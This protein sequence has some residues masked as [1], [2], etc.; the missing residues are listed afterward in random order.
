MSSSVHHISEELVEQSARIN[1]DPPWRIRTGLLEGR[2]L[3]AGEG[4]FT[5]A[6][7][8]IRGSILGSHLLS[9][10]VAVAIPHT[11]LCGNNS[12][13]TTSSPF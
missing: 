1:L 2:G 7:T 4:G 13:E 12:L 3:T 10:K 6:W 11:C 9:V 8:Y 5:F